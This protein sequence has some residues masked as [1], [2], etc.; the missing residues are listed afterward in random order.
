MKLRVPDW[1]TEGARISVNGVEQAAEAKPGTYATV[2]R[3]WKKGD[4]ITIDMPM[5]TRI[6]EAN[7]LVEESRGQVAVQR[8]P[9]VY[10][11]ESNDLN[12][13]SIDDIAIPLNAEFTPV[14]MT[15][16]G[17]RI[18]ALEGDVVKR[19]ETSWKGQLYRE[20][21]TGKQTVKVRL[22]PYYAW[23]N[24]GKSEMTV[25]MPAL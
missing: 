11:L 6:I 25:W 2:S 13:V 22:I 7:P 5:R 9:I 18:K 1:C 19:S 15:I 23:G 24:R 8:G 12:G 14:D 16:D 4:V 17:C 20:A 21:S 10:C 3:T